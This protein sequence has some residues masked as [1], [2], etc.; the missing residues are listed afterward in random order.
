MFY[1]TM[2][3]LIIHKLQVREMEVI[4]PRERIYDNLTRCIIRDLFEWYRVTSGLTRKIVCTC[5]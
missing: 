2:N 3:V 5:L 1:H 4:K